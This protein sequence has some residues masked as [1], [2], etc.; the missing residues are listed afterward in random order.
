MATLLKN[1]RVIV[2]T[3]EV[4]EKGMVFIHHDLITYVGP[5]KSSRSS[6]TD[7][8]FDL[9]G[10]TLLPGLI[11][12][13][14]HLCLD[15]SPDPM[16]SLSRNSIPQLTLKAAQHAR[17]TL[18]AGV[19]TV[20]DMGGRDYVDLAI[21]DEIESG[22]LEGP[23]M[24]C[25][26]K[27]V[28]MTGGHGWQFGREANGTDEVREAVRE[29]LKAGVNFVKL[30]ATG[31]VMTKGV[32]PGATQFT[33]EELIAG[34]EE[35]RKAGRRTA[36]HAQGTEGI[37][38]SLWAGVS[39]IEHGFFLDDEAIELMLEMNAYLV[40]TLCAPHHIIRGGVKGGVPRFAVEKSK[41]VMKSHFQSVR[42][43]HKSKVPIAMGTDAGTPFN[44][45]G[46]NLKEME[47]LVKTGLTPMEAIVATTL[48]A[49][50]V[51]GLEKKIGTLEKGKLADLVVIDGNPLK[52][53][54]LFQKKD[55][56][57]A[58]MKEG[59]F[60]KCQL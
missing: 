25:S 26:G 44:C 14:V 12:A 33:L 1:G 59:Q 41:S 19:T 60:Y 58:I 34:V 6:K 17:Q 15:G 56:I 46:E 21:R 48:T 29:Q 11:D 13:H 4:I 49:A 30:M 5:A 36:T 22:L 39:S 55:K 7:T 23:R 24:I 57:L 37:K 32:D 50:K 31:G 43:A 9:S 52:D 20:R 53:I 3:G 38:N 28:C 18:A 45:H 10:R 42:R 2:G 54:G 27:L 8:T 16:T 40:P 35:A 47:L 51:L